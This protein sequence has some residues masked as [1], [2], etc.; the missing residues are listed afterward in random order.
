MKLFADLCV[1]TKALT[2]VALAL[3]PICYAIASEVLP[4]KYRAIVQYWISILAG[5]GGFIGTIAGP[6]FLKQSSSEGWRYF[7][8]LEGAFFVVSLA[9]VVLFVG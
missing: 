9:G 3:K 1:Y 2:G 5:L 6:A 7:F 4:R 8:Y